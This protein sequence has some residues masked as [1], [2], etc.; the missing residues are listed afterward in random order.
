MNK[1]AP[2]EI[3]EPGGGMAVFRREGELAA[4]SDHTYKGGSKKREK[5]VVRIY[6]KLADDHLDS[7]VKW[8]YD[9]KDVEFVKGELCVKLAKAC[10]ELSTW[11][12]DQVEARKAEAIAAHKV[13]ETRYADKE[14]KRKRKKELEDK[15]LLENGN[16]QEANKV[17]DQSTLMLKYVVAIFLPVSVWLFRRY[18]ATDTGSRKHR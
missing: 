14:L 15:K 11:D 9:S 1:L 6:Q 17:Q 18:S 2:S 16:A 5:E 12:V 3:S 4:L 7:L 8:F 10:S 13:S